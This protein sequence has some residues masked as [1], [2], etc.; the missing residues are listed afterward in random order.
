MSP[1]KVRQLLAAF[2]S[3][4]LR[5][6]LS[7]ESTAVYT[8]QVKSGGSK[9]RQFTEGW[10]EFE[11]TKVAKKVAELLNARQVGGKK[12]SFWYEDVWNI[13]YL[14][15]FKWHHLTEPIGTPQSPAFVALLII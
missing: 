13:Q 7:P 11:D 6:F 2:Q 5:I 12:G 8:R 15:K 3:P 10:V 14:P 4:V 1:T 9:K